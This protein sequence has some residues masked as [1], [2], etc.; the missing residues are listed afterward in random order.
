MELADHGS[1]MFDLARFLL[2][3]IRRVSTQLASNIRYAGPEGGW[4]V[5]ANDTANCLL[6]F[7]SETQATVAISSTAYLGHV[8]WEQTLTVYGETGPLQMQI[9][10]GNPDKAFILLGA[11]SNGNY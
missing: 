9:Q 5:T 10:A 4:M 11:R 3:E 2:G 1:H 8:E 7:T 6:E